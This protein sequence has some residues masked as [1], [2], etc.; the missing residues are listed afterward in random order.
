MRR[1]LIALTVSAFFGASARALII[2]DFT[3]GPYSNT[4]QSGTVIASQTGTMVGGERDTMM[5]VTDNPFGFD[6][7][8]VINNGLAAISNDV[9]VDSLFGLDYDGV[10]EETGGEE[11][12]RGPGLG[13]LDL[14]TY[15]RIRFRFLENDQDLQLTVQFRTFTR[16]MSFG[17]FTVP[18]NHSPFTFDVLF[19]GLDSRGE[20]ADFSHIDRITLFFD[21]LPSA[22][23]AL[24][25]IQTVPEPATL[26]VL[27]AAVGLLA[28]RRRKR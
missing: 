3:S 24:Q 15:D 22:D 20:G 14:S 11:F 8:V 28:A 10:G 1:L 26:T 13:G 6:F 7:E 2:D 4:I 9:S 5:R 19:D 27:A 18:A 12:V 25:D 16:G 21:G 23:F 17:T